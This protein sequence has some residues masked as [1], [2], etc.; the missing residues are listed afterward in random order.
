MMRVCMQNHADL[1]IDTDVI[2]MVSTDNGMPKV[3]VVGSVYRG[4]IYKKVRANGND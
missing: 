3:G 4:A 1:K 2:A